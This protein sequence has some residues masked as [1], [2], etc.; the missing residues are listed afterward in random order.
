MSGHCFTVG[1]IG[2]ID[3]MGKIS[4]CNVLQDTEQVVVQWTHFFVANLALLF[5]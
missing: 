4:A 2:A 5:T 3:V 1:S